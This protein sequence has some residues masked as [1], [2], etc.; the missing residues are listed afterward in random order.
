MPRIFRTNPPACAPLRRALAPGQLIALGFAG[1]ILL[2]ALLLCLPAAQQDSVQVS[3]LDALFMSTSAVCITGLATADVAQTFTVFGRVVLLVLVQ[4][5]GLGITTVG[6]S[7]IML[8][9]KK[10]NLRQRMLV[11]EAFNYPTFK[12][13]LSLMKNILI[14]TFSIEG[15][16]ALLSLPVFLR[17]RPFL[18]ALG[19]SIFHSVAAFNNSGLD[20]LGR[21][22]SLAPYTHDVYFNLLT[23]LL[24]MLG[25][26]GFFVMFDLKQNRRWHKL[27]LQSRV[28][29]A[30]N[31]VL[32]L[33]GAVLIKLAQGDQITLL[34][35]WFASVSAR[36][37]GFATFPLS[38]FTNGALLVVM[39]LMF[40][41]AS[42]RSTG[43]GVKTTTMYVML[44]TLCAAPH[45]GRANVM[46]RPLAAG[47][48]EK[49]LAVVLLG[50]CVVLCAAFLLC[51]LEP[52]LDFEDIL[53]ETVSAFGT[54]GLSTG[55]TGGLCDASK[56]TLI[57]T[58][59]IGRLGPLS[60]AGLLSAAA[61]TQV[62]RAQ[63]SLSIG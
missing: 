55:I 60:A 5:G 58:M 14:V 29:L 30:V 48:A 57:F 8:A 62:R 52:Q 21:G 7:I 49:A 22:T 42:P 3:F 31:V 56:L 39:V 44:R 6:V 38:D 27:S 53:F 10:V 35:A 61:S 32:W 13:V 50:L 24:I 4:L 17:D 20:I 23:S 37:A 33:V 51:M 63:G 46:G 25:G 19:V 12:G 36:T 11:R 59:Y 16:G 34:G 40:I 54:V 1:V 15:I 9:G 18:P 2:G 45:Q 41:G 26:L 43:G 47:L 28:V